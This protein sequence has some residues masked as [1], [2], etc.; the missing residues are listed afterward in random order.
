MKKDSALNLL[1]K[2]S[3]LALVTLWLNGCVIANSPFLGQKGQTINSLRKNNSLSSLVFNENERYLQATGEKENEDC[4]VSVNSFTDDN[5][6]F[7]VKYLPKEKRK[8]DLIIYLNGLE[9]H[10][11]WFAPVAMLLA[12]KGIATYALDRRG[13]GINANLKGSRKDWLKDLEKIIEAAK[14]ESPDAHIH[15]TSL[16]FGSR[17]A[18]AYETGKGKKKVASQIFISPGFKTDVSPNYWENL[19][20]FWSNITNCDSFLIKSPVYD[21]KLFADDEK[22]R[23]AIN[24]D[25]LKV[26]YPQ[27]KDIYQGYLLTKK[28][29]FNQINSPLLVLYSGRDEIVNYPEVFSMLSQT[30]SGEMLFKN[31]E[32]DKHSLILENP[33]AVSR[34]I[35]NW[36]SNH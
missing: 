28:M 17:V 13:S 5:S 10:S 9:S 6:L 21:E 34:D 14:M 7:Y 24:E 31:Y 19:T 2:T 18:G 22:V 36:I 32:E 3:R 16:C 33:K 25:K 8:D 27:A 12:E 29:N 4:E 1:R 15:I 30:N 11:S 26:I 23:K 35:L 20:A